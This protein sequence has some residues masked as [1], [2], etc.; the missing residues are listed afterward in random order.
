MPY[1]KGTAHL[2]SAVA[3]PEMGRLLWRSNLPASGSVVHGLQNRLTFGRTTL[4][5][6]HPL[7]RGQMLL[8]FSF[9][10][11]HAPQTLDKL[12]HKTTTTHLDQSCLPKH[13]HAISGFP[14]GIFLFVAA[15]AIMS[16]CGVN[17]FTQALQ[18][19]SDHSTN[20]LNGG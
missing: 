15:C 9:S 20:G 17:T 6:G 2:V 7:P 5:H 12:D 8:L 13:F 3:P 11:R 18:A 16:G 10:S 1:W 19:P 4:F 14:A